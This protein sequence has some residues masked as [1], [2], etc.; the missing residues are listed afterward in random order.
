M[1]N[2]S[3][4]RAHAHGD[5][6][7]SRFHAI[8][9]AVDQGFGFDNDLIGS[10]TFNDLL[11]LSTQAD[12]LPAIAVDVELKRVIRTLPMRHGNAVT[13]GEP[14]TASSMS[15]TPSKLQSEKIRRK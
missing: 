10:G 6:R 11:Q 3:Q 13:I 1:W 12:I 8:P 5:S 9:H 7:L 14:A 2:V 4:V 15:K